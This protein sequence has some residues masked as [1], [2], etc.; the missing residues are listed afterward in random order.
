[1]FIGECANKVKFINGLSIFKFFFKTVKIAN[2]LNY[3]MFYNS[4]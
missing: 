4:T 2:F 3:N 1:M